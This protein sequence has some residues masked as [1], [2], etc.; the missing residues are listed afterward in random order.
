LTPQE[1]MAAAQD[2]LEQDPDP[3]TRAELRELLSAKNTTALRDRFE[4]SLTF[5]TAGL[6]AELGAGPNRMNRL[7]VT[8]TAAGIANWLKEHSESI[9]PSVVIGYDARVN[10]RTFAQDSAAVFSA[11]GIHALVFET[12]IATPILAFAVKQ[13]GY[14]LGVM[15]TASHNPAKDNGYKVYLG[16]SHGGSQIVSPVDKQMATAIATVAKTLRYEQISRT[17][18]FQ[19]GGQEIIDAYLAATAALVQPASENQ[20]K[21]VYTALHGVGWATTKRLFAS[22]GLHEP[23]GVSQQLEPDGNFPTT[24][25]PNPEEPGALDLAFLKAVEAKADLIIAHDPDADR[26]AVAIP[27]QS[28]PPYRRLT[29]DEV[30][31]LLGHHLAQKAQAAGQKGTLATTIVSSSALAKVAKKHKLKY[32]ETLTGFKHLARVSDLIFGFEEALGY[33]V[34]PSRVADKDG[35]SAALV[36]VTLANELA[37]SG[38]NIAKQLEE[39]GK[40]YGHF[41]TSQITV[42]AKKPADLARLMNKLRQKPPAKLDRTAYELTDLLNSKLRLP[43]TDLL[44]YQLE[45]GRRIVIRPS[46]TE[47]K[48]KCYLQVEAESAAAATDGLHHLEQVARKLL[49]LEQSG[50]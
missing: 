3:L 27:T 45:D 24:D 14:S 35:I 2:W 39:L 34:N 41:A 16:G 5:G 19:T 32:I 46:G 12:A 37:E 20:V 6:R 7:V 22:V 44:R 13:Y 49:G 29:G 17:E 18:V 40:L 4:S 43:K 30:G 10:S 42:K 23:I 1:L 26:L 28:E 48:L 21:V 11:A 9:T 31:L 33:S 25:F 38:S 36:M 8:Q 50:A 47:P 15:V